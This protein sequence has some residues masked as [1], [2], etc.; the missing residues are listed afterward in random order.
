M[1]VRLSAEARQDLLAIADYIA[2][3]N[4]TRALSFVL[5]LTQSCASLADM[6]RANA[7]VARYESHG[8]RR[9]VH[10]NYSV[11][12]R[13]EN[14]HIAVIRILHGARDHEALL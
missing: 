14:E 2:R 13:I 10:G 12:Y 11:F 9:R 8:I 1:K 4:P 3:D 6:P 7:V 5:E